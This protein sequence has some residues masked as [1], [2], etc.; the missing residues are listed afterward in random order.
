MR[1]RRVSGVPEM[2]KAPH[3]ASYAFLAMV[4]ISG[5]RVW[6]SVDPYDRLS[7]LVILPPSVRGLALPVVCFLESA[8]VAVLSPG[9]S[10]ERSLSVSHA[11]LRARVPPR[12]MQRPA[13]WRASGRVV[14]ASASTAFVVCVASAAVALW[15]VTEAPCICARVRASQGRC[16]RC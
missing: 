14:L 16:P 3:G 8:V 6:C 7:H 15:S 2:W 13:R 11:V 4:G 12:Q 9:A 1:V 5:V 10:G